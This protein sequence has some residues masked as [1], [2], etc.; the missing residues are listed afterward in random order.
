MRHMRKI[1]NWLWIWVFW[2]FL[3]GGCSKAIG[4]FESGKSG[5]SGEASGQAPQA[6]VSSSEISVTELA[7]DPLPTDLVT[8]PSFSTK[9]FV[10]AREVYTNNS[11][12]PVR[13]WPSSQP[14]SLQLKTQFMGQMGTAP[15]HT[16]FSELGLILAVTSDQ[17]PLVMERLS[18]SVLGSSV[19][20]AAGEKVTLNWR[21]GPAQNSLL[22]EFN[23]GTVTATETG[24]INMD[25]SMTT[26]ATGSALDLSFQRAV[27]AGDDSA[28][29]E[30]VLPSETQT[31]HSST[32]ILV[33]GSLPQAM[34][35]NGVYT[36]FVGSN[37]SD[38]YSN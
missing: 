24:I 22:C 17:T 1:Q 33:G 3:L 27:Q 23:Q 9:G 32:G 26:E 14:S 4:T 2:A 15:S 35:C 31:I 12:H 5:D 16:Y 6:A 7:T 13:L 21:I 25:I 20:L 11:S 18:D 28:H 8:E 38:Y 29:L 30:D 34:Q 37:F 19:L 10:V 36:D